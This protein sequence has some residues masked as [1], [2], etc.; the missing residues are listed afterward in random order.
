LKQHILYVCL[1]FYFGT[2]SPAQAGEQAKASLVKIVQKGESYQLTRN[3]QP[4]FIQGVGGT[5]NLD[6]LA[7]MGGNSIRTWGTDNLEALLNEAQRLGLT[8]TVG[9]WLGHERHGFNYNNADQVAKQYDMARQTILKFKDHPAVL[10]WGLGNE[11][12]GYEAGDNAAIWSAVNNIAAMVK[13]LDPHHPTM[14]VVAEIGGERV[15]NIHRLCPDID[16]IGI[17]S[18]GGLPSLP[19]RYRQAG[20]KKPFIITEFGPPGMWEVPKNAWGTN[21]EPTSTAKAEFY[22]KGYEEGILGAKGLCL[23]SY[24]FLWGNKQEGTGTWFGMLLP[25]GSRLAAADTMQELW[26]GKPPANPCP[27]IDSLQ[28]EGADQVEPGATVHAKL[29]A[30]PAKGDKLKVKW[31]LQ[32]DV[33]SNSVGVDEEVPPTFPD[34]IVKG[35]AK[36]AEVRMPKGGGGYRLF[37]FVHDDQGGAAA[38]NVPLFVKGPVILPQAK[39]ASLPLVV[40]DEGDQPKQPFIPTG[41]MGNTKGLRVDISCDEM[42]HAGKTCL[43]VEYRDKEGWAGVVWQNPANN[44]GDQ[45]G[46]WNLTG[47]KKLTFWGRGAKGDEV[48]NFEFG[49]IGKDKKSPDTGKGK[50]ERVK[51]S[52]DWQ[53]YTIDLQGKDLTRIQTGFALV[54]SGQGPPVVFFLDDVKYE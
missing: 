31:V 2:L 25:D 49:L 41:W 34:A 38:A 23:G 10:L 47:A 11:M 43:R 13:R 53:Q 7:K 40:Y 9:I 27:R 28:V 29:A 18:Y 30:S 45:P 44:W 48:V 19:K 54:V 4:Y 15:K 3:G 21:A 6:L 20:G 46:G 52:K 36:Q 14:T 33:S 32:A 37:A 51:L 1:A 5:K 26:T 8:V 24:A 39:P 16:I 17:N 42:P 50:L 22:R 12:E 35:D